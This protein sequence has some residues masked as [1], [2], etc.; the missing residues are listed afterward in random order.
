MGTREPT[1]PGTGTTTARGVATRTART[2]LLDLQ[3]RQTAAIERQSNGNGGILGLLLFGLIIAG[4]VWAV[5]Q[6]VAIVG[7]AIGKSNPNPP[8]DQESELL[9]LLRRHDV[10]PAIV[11]MA[12]RETLRRM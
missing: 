6:F 11:T 4:L 12:V 7:R 5:I 10:D 8:T 3:R 9:G 1:H 2:E